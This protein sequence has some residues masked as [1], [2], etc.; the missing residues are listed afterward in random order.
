[1]KGLAVALVAFPFCGFPQ[2]LDRLLEPIE[3]ESQRRIAELNRRILDAAMA[4][5]ADG[6]RR[7]G[8]IDGL[9]SQVHGEVDAYIARTVDPGQPDP[10]KVERNLKQA[11]A[12][13]ADG[14]PR[15]FVLSSGESSSLLVVYTL[16]PAE[17]MGSHATSG[18][19]RAYSAERGRFRLADS[20]GAD[21]D[22]Y[23]SICLRK[24]HT[25]VPDESWLLVWGQMTGANGPNI[26][27]R[28]YALGGG[29]FRTMWV[30]ENSWGA[31]TVHVTDNGFTVDGDYYHE[32]KVRHDGYTLSDDG[33][34]RTSRGSK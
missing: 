22:G 21:M 6:T 31:I 28:V 16:H 23:I 27:M 1:M 33:L 2:S 11:L 4:S 29:K 34:Y 9:I 24:L 32:I 17:W 8:A 13:L 14:S 12:A 15:V 25:P 7:R 10:R 19:L 30:P 20:T 26:R 3:L 5:P 18:T